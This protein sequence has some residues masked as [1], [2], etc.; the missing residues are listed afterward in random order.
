MRRDEGDRTLLDKVL[1][2]PCKCLPHN[3]PPFQG[4]VGGGSG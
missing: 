3:P 4:G 1:A 2:I